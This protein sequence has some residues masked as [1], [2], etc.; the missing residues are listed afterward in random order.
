M[1]GPQYP[2]TMMRPRFRP[3]VVPA[4]TRRVKPLRIG[5]AIA[6]AITLL[7]GLTKRGVDVLSLAADPTLLSIGAVGLTSQPLC[8]ASP[9]IVATFLCNPLQ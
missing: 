8:G 5:F 2:V 9:V 1:F 4:P 7:G 6:A 3:H